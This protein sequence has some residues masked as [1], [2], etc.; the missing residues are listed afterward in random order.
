VLEPVR[1]K[2][3]VAFAGYQ[4]AAVATLFGYFVEAALGLREAIQE[5]RASRACSVLYG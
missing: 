4:P 3:A 1:S 2:L 5:L